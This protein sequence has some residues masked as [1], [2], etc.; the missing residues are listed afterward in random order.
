MIKKPYPVHPFLLVLFP[1]IFTL[2]HNAEYIR[3]FRVL[4]PGGALLACTVVAVGLAWLVFRDIHKGAVAVSAAVFAFFSFGHVGDMIT[5]LNMR[6]KYQVAA[7]AVFLLVVAVVVWWRK[8]PST[9]TKILNLIG[10]CLLGIS[11]LSY[12]YAAFTAAGSSGD[13]KDEPASDRVGAPST[14]KPDE[15]PDIYYLILERYARA[16]VLQEQ[17][18]F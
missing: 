4:E 16:D 13:I 6:L 9:L 1:V 10:A 7:W 3:P 11:V 18:D 15:L 14:G 2:S 5:V 8:T 12:A 17:Y